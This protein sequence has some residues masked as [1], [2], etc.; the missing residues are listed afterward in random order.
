MGALIVFAILAII[1]GSYY[2]QFKT[3]QAR[4]RAVAAVA[5][6]VG[7]TFT[8]NDTHGIAYL[9]FTLFKQGK[10][11]KASLVISGTHNG[12]PLNI[13]DYEY[14][15]QGN[16]SREY[17]RFTCAVL[18]IPAACPPLRLTHENFLTL[19]GDHLGHHDVKLEYDDF[20]RRFNVSCEDQKFA[21]TLLDGAMMQWLLDDDKIQHLEIVGPFV[22]F[23]SPRRKPAV[24]LNLGTWLDGFQSHI[25]PLLYTAYPPREIT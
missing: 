20:N 16:R 13:F 2:V 22:L 8:G 12:V 23:A 6:S 5:A 21:F 7:F 17:H 3:R 15:V 24:W 1:A 10:G 11:R 14:Y 19:L 4:S 25:P 9:P 18:T